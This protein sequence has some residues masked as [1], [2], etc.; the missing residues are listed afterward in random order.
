MQP[1]GFGGDI[2]EGDWVDN[3]VSTTSSHTFAASS[4]W[5]HF[6]S[7]ASWFFAVVTG[8][9]LSP[10]VVALLDAH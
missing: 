7:S 9:L 6:T 4:A 10:C 1:D 5:Q 2:Y 8:C 3:Q